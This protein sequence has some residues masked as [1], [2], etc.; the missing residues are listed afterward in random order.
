MKLGQ[1]LLYPG[2]IVLAFCL[3]I[4]GHGYFL[5]QKQLAAKRDVDAA[6][7][8]ADSGTAASAGDDTQMVK[9]APPLASQPMPS[10]QQPQ[11]PA[12]F[13]AEPALPPPSVRK[14]CR[15]SRLTASWFRRC[16]SCSL[17]S[18]I[19]YCTAPTARV[20]AR[21][22]SWWRGQWA[23][24]DFLLLLSSFCFLVSRPLSRSPLS[25][26]FSSI[27]SIFNER[28]FVRCS[29]SR[30][31]VVTLKSVVAVVVLVV[32]WEVCSGTAG[33]QSESLPFDTTHGQPP[34]A[35]STDAD[36]DDS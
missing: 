5:R 17:C 1:G 29:F 35:P 25:P 10:Q 12:P 6:G 28:L 34:I 8:A 33:W 15:L 22:K 19:N 3:A 23:S 26:L 16:V 36:S 30:H 11:E 21:C 20:R 2:L 24:D 18:T 27:R 7:A 14:R 32:R 9:P 13:G 31:V 4:L